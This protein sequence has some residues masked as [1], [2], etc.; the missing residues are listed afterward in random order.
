MIVL[1]LHNVI[2]I[3][4]FFDNVLFKEFP[5]YPRNVTLTCISAGTYSILVWNL[6]KELK[7]NKESNIGNFNS[8]GFAERSFV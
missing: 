4:F 1:T 8:Y 3:I 6:S 7:D 5:T 2:D